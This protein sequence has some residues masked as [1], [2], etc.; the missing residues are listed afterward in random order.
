MTQVPNMPPNAPPEPLDA[1]ERELARL[2]RALPAAAP[3]PELDARILGAARRA[4]HRAQPRKRGRGW[5]VGL[6]TAASALLALGLFVRMHRANDTMYTLPS[7][8]MNETP[9]HAPMPGGETR[10]AKEQGRSATAANAAEDTDAAPAAA[11][12]EAMPG[13]NA[14]RNREAPMA[15]GAPAPAEQQAERQQAQGILQPSDAKAVAAKQAPNAFPEAAAAPKPLPPPP[16]APVLANQPAMAPP[17]APVP[18][19]PAATEERK[20]EY[21]YIGQRDESAA[22]AS[23]ALKKDARGQANAVAADK[24]SAAPAAAQVAGGKDARALDRVDVTGSRIKRAVDTEPTQPV[25]TLTRSDISPADDA[26]TQAQAWKAKP[27]SAA[28]TGSADRESAEG[29]GTRR[30][31]AVNDEPESNDG[32][33][34]KL[35]ASIEADMALPPAKWIARIRARLHAG[36][37][38]GARESLRRFQAHYPDEDIPADLQPLLK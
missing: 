8:A 13:A 26:A 4:V 28:S 25:T 23:G 5:L 12:P 29:Y 32:E 16:P 38:E 37:R 19:R 14:E 34:V 11:P 1:D 3:P 33:K 15:A 9:V 31:P 27:A 35:N 10:A 20:A 30:T 2:L 17:A 36:Y 24:T 6:G 21:G 7:D 22:S 18:A